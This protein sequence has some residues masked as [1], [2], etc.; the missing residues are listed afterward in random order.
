MTTQ[1]STS[2]KINQHGKEH[3]AANT[4]PPIDPEKENEAARQH[5]EADEDP[6]L[7]D[8]E[9]AEIAELQASDPGNQGA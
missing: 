8:A 4:P 9:E 7:A 1:M 3:R 6:A 5:A 2:K